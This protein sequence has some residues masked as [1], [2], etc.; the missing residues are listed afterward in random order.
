MRFHSRHRYDSHVLRVLCLLAVC[1]WQ[2]V[3]L[4]APSV[5]VL[6]RFFTPEDNVNF[7]EDCDCAEEQ[8]LFPVPG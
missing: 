7:R 3:L 2:V 5:S 1:S 6:L 4:S 8:S